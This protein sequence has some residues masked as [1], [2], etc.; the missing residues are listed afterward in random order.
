MY[1]PTIHLNG[2]SRLTLL[3]QARAAATA[4]D[5]AI[6]AMRRMSPNGRDYYPQGNQAIRAAMLEHTIRLSTLQEMRAEIGAYS[7]RI[8]MA[9]GP[10]QGVDEQALV[11][12][13]REALSTALDRYGL[14]APDI[15][16]GE[17]TGEDEDPDLRCEVEEIGAAIKAADA[18]LSVSASAASGVE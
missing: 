4:L 13:L 8:R 12:Q 5:A 11:G 1:T 10:E 17:E 3:E 16:P 9:P 2:T 7:K 6:E 14:I 18:F 15:E